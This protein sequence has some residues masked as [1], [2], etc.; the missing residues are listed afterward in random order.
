MS[1]KEKENARLQQQKLE[2]EARRKKLEAQSEELARQLIA[3]QQASQAQI[4]A[5]QQKH[6]KGTQLNCMLCCSHLCRS[7][8]FQTTK[9]PSIKS[10]P[11]GSERSSRKRFN[12]ICSRNF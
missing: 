4:L 10:T 11:Q 6:Q 12:T 8:A 9:R 2:E 1:E 5:V 7:G 3:E